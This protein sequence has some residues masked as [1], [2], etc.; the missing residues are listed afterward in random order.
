MRLARGVRY[1]LD[2]GTTIGE[3]CRRVADEVNAEMERIGLDNY[4]HVSRYQTADDVRRAW[5][6]HCDKLD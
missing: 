1:Y 2:E 6:R 4:A 5:Y 3:A